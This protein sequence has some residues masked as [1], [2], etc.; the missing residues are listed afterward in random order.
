[1]KRNHVSLHRTSES[2][3]VLGGGG[4]LE[5]YECYIYQGRLPIAIEIF[6]T[7]YN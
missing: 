4:I 1:M 5:D 3:P 6:I 7:L 2:T